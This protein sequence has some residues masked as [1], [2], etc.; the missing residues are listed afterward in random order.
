MRKNV[1]NS[2]IEAF[3]MAMAGATVAAVAT[4]LVPAGVLESMAGSTGVT[5]LV[6]AARAPLGDTARAL[7]AFGT[8]AMTLAILAYFL[9]RQDSA[10]VLRPM[11]FAPASAWAGDDTARSS[12]TRL[13]QIKLPSVT[14]LNMPWT[15]G[16]DDITE[17]ADL[18]KLRHG[19]SHPDAPPRRPLVASTDLPA[20]DLAG[21]PEALVVPETG[22]TDA[23]TACDAS[24]QVQAGQKF[25]VR[26][27]LEPS[28]AE[29]VAQLEAAVAERQKQLAELEA[30]AAE[31]ASS[32]GSVQPMTVE[33]RSVPEAEIVTESE[34]IADPTR[35]GRPPLEAVP[36]ASV[37]D[38]DMDL[39]LAA[40]LA[41]LHRMNATG[42]YSSSN[43]VS[44][45]NRL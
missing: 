39:A 26:V 7:I 25:T 9:S 14:R 20:L 35:Y 36:S 29:M 44:I 17:L 43:N 1:P 40:A 8:G 21:L 22:A 6:P 12:K 5:E 32:H 10:S 24:Q 19:D 37:G 28:L 18:P 15:K 3:A 31:L 45:I 42:R 27:D 38:D 16:D 4:M 11:P 30:V 33:E 2:Q 23:V 41:T 34:I 13:A